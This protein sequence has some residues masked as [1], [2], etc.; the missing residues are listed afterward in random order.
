MELLQDLTLEG[1]QVFKVQPVFVE[2]QAIS[3]LIQ[4]LGFQGFLMVVAN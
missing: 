2:E 3:D 4:R 1:H